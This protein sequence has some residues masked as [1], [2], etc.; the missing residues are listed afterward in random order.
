MGMV[1]TVVNAVSTPNALTFTSIMDLTVP[2][3]V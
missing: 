1:G 2:A 3:G